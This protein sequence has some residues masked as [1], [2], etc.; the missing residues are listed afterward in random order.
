M[1]DWQSIVLSNVQPRMR[2]RTHLSVLSPSPI[3]AA[4]SRSHAS[5]IVSDDDDV[6]IVLEVIAN[7]FG[8]NAEDDTGG[9]LDDDQE[10]LNSVLTG[11]WKQRL[12]QVATKQ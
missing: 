5:I 12:Q 7:R 11:N 9:V 6:A 8:R 10:I 1:Q 3:V 2:T 4:F